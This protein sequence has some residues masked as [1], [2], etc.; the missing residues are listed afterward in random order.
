MRDGRSGRVAVW[1]RAAFVA[2]SVGMVRDEEDGRVDSLRNFLCLDVHEGWGEVGG[3]PFVGMVRAGEEM[4]VE[5][6][7]EEDREEKEGGGYE[8]IHMHG[9]GLGDEEKLFREMAV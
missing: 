4:S 7:G 5:R 3:G 2:W 9:K 6:T 8:E 1:W